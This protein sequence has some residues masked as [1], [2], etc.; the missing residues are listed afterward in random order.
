MCNKKLI[1]VIKLI[2][3]SFLTLLLNLL[4]FF[5]TFIVAKT[6]GKDADDLVFID[7][8]ESGNL[9]WLCCTYVG[10]LFIEILIDETLKTKGNWKKGFM[11]MG[12]L[13]M[14][15]TT[16]VYIM[17]KLAYLNLSE[18][19]IREWQVGYTLGIS[20][21]T[22]FACLTFLITKTIIILQNKTEKIVG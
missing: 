20:G 3:K 10:L 6:Y 11:I 17:V 18:K 12:G 19:M 7:L 1:E 15:L 4:P 16:A 21:A 14:L 8:I 5:I 2:G 13:I 9:I 22:V